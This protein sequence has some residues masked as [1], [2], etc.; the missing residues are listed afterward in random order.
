MKDMKTNWR[1][2][3][4]CLICIFLVFVIVIFAAKCDDKYDNTTSTKDVVNVDSI[5]KTNDS[6]KI[7]IKEKDS[8]K[9]EEVFKVRNLDTDST[10]KLFKELVRE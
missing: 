7:I 1:D 10:I 4:V 2:T 6:I 9:Y 5:I 3:I 8:V